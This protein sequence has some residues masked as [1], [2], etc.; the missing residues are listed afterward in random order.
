MPLMN[1]P[2]TSRLALPDRPNSVR[3]A[4]GFAHATLVLTAE[5]AAPCGEL[6]EHLQP[7]GQEAAS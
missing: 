5:N 6:A 1:L 7:S 4:P 2:D 3:E